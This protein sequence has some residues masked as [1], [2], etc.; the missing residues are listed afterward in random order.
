MKP[1]FSLTYIMKLRM[2]KIKKV[3]KQKNPTKK[4]SLMKLNKGLK[5]TRK[6]FSKS[7]VGMKIVLTSLELRRLKTNSWRRNSWLFRMIMQRKIL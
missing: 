2:K 4:K 1:I 6:L 7:L 3:I 5:L